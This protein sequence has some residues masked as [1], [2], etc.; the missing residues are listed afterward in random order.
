MNFLHALN[1]ATHLAVE[2]KILSVTN[3]IPIS[4]KAGWIP[5]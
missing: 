5:F 1:R 2:P 3:F 4:M